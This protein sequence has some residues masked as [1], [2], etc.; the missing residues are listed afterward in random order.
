MSDF[1]QPPPPPSTELAEGGE[2]PPWTGRPQGPPP[3]EV[4]SEAVLFDSDTVTLQIV[5]LD[6]YP[7]GFE[8]EIHA[9][10]TIAWN[11]LSRPADSG[12]DVFGRHWPMVGE[13]RDELPPQLLRVGVQFADGRQA[14]NIGGHDRPAGG[15]IVWPLKGGGSGRP[16]GSQFRQ[17]YWISPLPP[18]GPISI[19]CEWPVAGIPVVHHEL[20]AQRILDAAERARTVIATDGRVARSGQTWRLAADTDVAWIN[21][22]TA[23]STAITAA[24]PPIFAAYCTLAMPFRDNHELAGHERALIELLTDHTPEQAWWLGYLDTG[25]S[26]VV[27]PYAP[28]T[29]VYYGYGYVLVAGGPE[30]AISWRAPGSRG[31]LPDLIFPQDRSWL[32]S[33]MW[34]DQWTCIGGSEPLINRIRRHPLLDPIARQVDPAEDATPP[35]HEAI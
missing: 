24:I 27:F 6:A 31:G 12:P 20:D 9:R 17:G 28:R 3:G 23:P 21:T 2:A 22:G 29:T 18:P 13:P 14:T 10:T 26:D 34:D 32:V 4:L 7:D 16:T 15:P 8:L 19:V 35:G 5:Y 30:Q 25:A 11:D 33:T 1:F